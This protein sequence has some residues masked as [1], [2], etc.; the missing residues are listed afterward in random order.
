MAIRLRFVGGKLLALCAARTQPEPGDHFLDDGEHYALS[1]KFWRDYPQV[2]IVDVEA[3][4]AIEAAEGPD[5]SE[6][7]EKKGDD[8]KDKN[9][10]EPEGT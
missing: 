6:G 3:F 4:V 5:W 1:Q 8:M 9:E 2:G 7:T 10:A